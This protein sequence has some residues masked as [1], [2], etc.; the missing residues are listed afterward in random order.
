MIAKYRRQRLAKIYGW[1]IT[2]AGL[3]ALSTPVTAR[4]SVPELPIDPVIIRVSSAG[5]SSPP[6]KAP[7]PPPALLPPASSLQ[8]SAAPAPATT[9]PPSTPAPAC[10]GSACCECGVDW[11]KIPP[12]RALPR[13]GYFTIPPTGCGY[14][15]FLD[16]LNGCCREKPPIMPYGFFGFYQPSFYDTDFR[17]LD[18]PDNKQCDYWDPV[19]RIHCGDNWLFST[20]GQTWFR[21]MNEVDRQ[22]TTADNN[23]GLYRGRIYG[24]AWYK[25]Q[26]RFFIEY[27]YADSFWFDVNPLPIDIN[28]SDFQNLFIELKV[29][30]IG[31]QPVYTRIGRQ[32]MYMGSQRLISGLDWANTRR[33]F[34]GVRAYR[35][36]EK[37][38][39]DAFWVQPVIVNRNELDSVDNNQNFVGFWGTYKPRKGTALDMY[40]L[41]LDNTN[42]VATGTN[43]VTKGFT[44]HTIGSR[45]SG[46]KDCVL[47][48]FEGMLQLGDW[49][50]Q[51]LVAG[52]YTAGLGYHFKCAPMNPQFWVYYDW[53]SGESTPGA[54]GTRSTFQQL[55]PFGHYYFG[56]LDLVGRQNIQDVSCQAVVYPTN[57]IT[58]IVQ[59]HRFWLAEPAD[60]LYNA[61]GRVVR[62][63]PTGSSGRD[64]GCELDF[65]LSFHLS[66]H[67]DVLLGWSKLFRGDFVTNTG[68][69]VSPEL[70][71]VQYGYRW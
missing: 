29:G 28:R 67:S 66:T 35:T 40:Y 53:A 71:Y 10:C 51:D 12:V 19:K 14:Y 36:D 61:A 70:F 18:K 39:F 42:N 23:Y 46:D 49:S 60:A 20:G 56:F 41:M 21:Q 27:L 16:Q 55:F 69:A 44:A 45:Y 63:D 30:E 58:G 68:P 8:N 22:L 25:D 57:W 17:Y 24:D 54:G 62:N 37:F 11:T 4:D 2:G 50:N 6:A 47:W 31:C 33:T 26:F 13:P 34:Q 15:S 59:F 5:E 43:R 52:A 9:A 38:D 32:E 48:D 65:V 1:V 3:A 7:P 64:V